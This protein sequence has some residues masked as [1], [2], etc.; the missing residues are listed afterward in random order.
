MSDFSTDEIWKPV[1]I[2]PGYEVS[3]KGRVRSLDR[4][5]T[6]TRDGKTYFR[7]F[8]GRIMRQE[9]TRSGSTEIIYH[10]I[11]LSKYGRHF[12]H[13]LVNTAFNGPRVGKQETRHLNGD[14]LDN[15]PENLKW[16]THSENMLDRTRHGTFRNGNTMKTHCHKGHPFS[17]DNLKVYR[18]TRICLVCRRATAR[19]WARAKRASTAPARA[20]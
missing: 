11:H 13:V 4:M 6:G 12:V 10:R 20:A 16:D 7:S 9:R 14:H 5:I 18:G 3:N 17:G 2:A 1:T 15:R 19:E 8:P